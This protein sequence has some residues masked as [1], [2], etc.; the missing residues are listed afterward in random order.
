[1]RAPFLVRTKEVQDRRGQDR[2]GGES[3][4]YGGIIISECL[5]PCLCGFFLDCGGRLS[6]LVGGWFGIIIS[7]LG[8]L[9]GKGSEFES[10]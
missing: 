1:M 2:R 10:D 5:F 3:D 4:R 7:Y 9:M 8:G 6:V